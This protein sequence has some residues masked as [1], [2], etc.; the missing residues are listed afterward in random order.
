MREKGNGK[1]TREKKGE[2][3]RKKKKEKG[4]GKGKRKR[5]E[6][7][8]RCFNTNGENITSLAVFVLFCFVFVNNIVTSKIIFSNMLNK[9]STVMP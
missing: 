6:R 5:K 3:R 2:K 1:E 8:K 9:S 4:K 7:N